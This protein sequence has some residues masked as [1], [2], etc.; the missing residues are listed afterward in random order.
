MNKGSMFT[1]YFL[2]FVG[3]AIL[4]MVLIY[5]MIFGGLGIAKSLLYYDA[6]TIVESLASDTSAVASH[7]G[8]FKHELIYKGSLPSGICDL[9][10][11]GNKISMK[12]PEQVLPKLSAQ[13]I[14]TKKIQIK[15][16]EAQMDIPV[17]NYVQIK[18]FT[19][20]CESGISK[21]IVIHKEG[22]QIWF[23]TI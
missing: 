15:E 1:L 12:I 20:K 7:N 5:V 22:N 4:A 23:S 13:E 16:S 18:S 9:N 10:I 17:P 8:D 3:G 2:L 14:A 21:S 11:V 6:R 19:A